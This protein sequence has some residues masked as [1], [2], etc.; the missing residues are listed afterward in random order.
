MMAF[1]TEV[2][3]S[4]SK[5]EAAT[6]IKIRLTVRLT[7]PMLAPN[8][9]RNLNRK[10]SKSHRNI[11]IKNFPKS[12]HGVVKLVPGNRLSFPPK[13][14]CW[15]MGP[16][17]DTG[18]E[19]ESQCIPLLVGHVLGLVHLVFMLIY[20]FLKLSQYAIILKDILYRMLICLFHII[21]FD[22]NI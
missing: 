1:I 17:L 3:L 7:P 9:S 4:L 11:K 6:V 12:S 21:I 8:S 18:H 13:L 19:R 20:P 2:S 16:W 15:L 5:I 10:N 14:G 22:V